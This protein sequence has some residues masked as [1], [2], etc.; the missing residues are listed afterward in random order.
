MLQEK[1]Y[2]GNLSSKRDWGHAKDYV[3]GMWRILQQEKPQ[4]YVLATGVTTTIR[5]FCKMA[6]K[7][8]G[9]DIEFQG[10]GVDEK[11]IDKETGKVI[12]EVDPRY[13]RPTEVDLLLGDCSKARKE[14]GWTPK[15]DLPMLVKEMV[16]ID[17]EEAKKSKFLLEEGYEV[18][19]SQEA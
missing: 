14:L 3:E 9:M 7:E 5:D 4:D 17:M 15:Y 10:E 1:L 13:F 11:G 16:E 12:I 19:E 8:V 6:F 18:T 2:L